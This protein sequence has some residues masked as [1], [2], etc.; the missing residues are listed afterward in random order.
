MV[1]RANKGDDDGGKL[2]LVVIMVRVTSMIG[3]MMDNHLRRTSFVGRG[4]KSRGVGGVV[5][6][7]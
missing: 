4:N 1:W 2:F 5:P 3:I 7:V 6:A